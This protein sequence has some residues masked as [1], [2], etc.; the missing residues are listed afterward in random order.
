MRRL[1][2]VGVGVAITVVVARKVK[3]WA[4]QQPIVKVALEGQETITG[5]KN[6]AQSFVGEFNSARS[7][8]EAD[9]RASLLASAAS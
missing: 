8:R 7:R 6:V 1:F 2:W 3:A 9:L 4:D 5:I